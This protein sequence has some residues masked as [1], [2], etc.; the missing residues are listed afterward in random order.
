MFSDGIIFTTLGEKQQPRNEYHVPSSA[1][2]EI[3]IS[4]FS[5]S[6]SSMFW[7][8]PEQLPKDSLELESQEP[9]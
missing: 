1:M 5:S 6:D 4:V 3:V 9:G 8:I 2:T 7:K